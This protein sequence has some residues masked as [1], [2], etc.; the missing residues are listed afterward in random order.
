MSFRRSRHE[1][2]DDAPVDVTGA[3]HIWDS[4]EDLR[5][6]LRAGKG[7]LHEKTGDGC[8]NATCIL[9]ATL[10]EPLLHMMFDQNHMKL[11]EVDQLRDE[12]LR[13]CELN[14]QN[15]GDDQLAKDSWTIKKHL[16]H[17]K[18]KARRREL[19]RDPQLIL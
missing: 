8:D 10:L 13:V 17:V 9:N 12:I 6:P 15:V 7:L 19:P 4:V 2:K 5:R 3:S 11:P 14:G 18:R 16:G 1:K